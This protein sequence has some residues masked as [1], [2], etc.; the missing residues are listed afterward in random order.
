[1]N[2]LWINQYGDKLWAHNRKELIA[3][4]SERGLS[5]PN[6]RVSLMYQDKKDGGTVRCGYVVA[7][8][9][10]SQFMPVESPR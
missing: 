10:W 2:Y 7:S 5:S 9:W 8:H 3:A 1:M 4:C 6:P